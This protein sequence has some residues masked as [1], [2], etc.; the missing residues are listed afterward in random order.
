MDYLKKQENDF[1]LTFKNIKYEV[2][3]FNKDKKEYFNK[4]I[5]NNAVG[6]CKS[7]E[8]TAIMGPSGSGKTSLLNF[9]T[10]R[11]EFS[12]DST[13][14][15]KIYVNSQEISFEE[16]P[17]YSSYVMQ[18]DVL[19][20]VLT[21]YE[22]IKFGCQL[23]RLVEENTTEEC[24]NKFLSDLQLVACKDTLVG[25]PD[26]K[27]I[28][29]GERKRTSIGMELIS[30]PSILFL[31]EPTSG[32]D[33]Q[34]SL[35]VVSL[36]KRVA[37]EKNVAVICTIHQPS[38]NIFNIFDQLI[39]IERGNIIYNDSPV[40]ITSYFKS[41]GK[42]LNEHANPADAFMRT[43]EENVNRGEDPDFFINSYKDR[44]TNYDKEISKQ[45]E[46]SKVGNNL[47][48]KLNEAVNLWDATM[49]L[50]RRA[51]TNVLRNPNLLGA[52][53]GFTLLFGFMTAS[54]FWKLSGSNYDGIYGRIGFSFFV[55][56]N[57]FM[58]QVMGTILSFPIERAVFIREHS[59]KMYGVGEYYLAKNIVET[60]F[61]LFFTT[62][63]VI[64]VYFTAGLRNDGAEHFF[65]FL[66]G[67]LLHCLCAQSL[68]YAV[69]TLFSRVSE[70]MA[71]INILVMPFILFSG[72]LINDDSMPRWLHWIKYISPI[73][74]INEIVCLNE[75]ENN[76]DITYGGGG[77][78]VIDNLNLEIGKKNGF[79]VLGAM[80][81][82][83]RILG[84]VFLK[85]LI[86][87]TG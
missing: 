12:K 43:L 67:F 22:N 84:Y 7:G 30:N 2:K 20:D 31:D 71:T 26:M 87:K 65:I 42:P 58:S 50:S 35:K 54:V 72:T 86:R 1:T 75:F 85:L 57:I 49:I 27:G 78:E 61:I 79:I 76:P 10:N 13:H 83:Y 44:I 82:A 73:K 81:I 8:L 25:N 47:S 39:I 11:I 70:A 77:E 64:I 46:D 21:P 15:G 68:G 52:R 59:S 56:V 45:I 60:P 36:L 29:G 69:G 24:V 34:T 80:V 28:S 6:Q 14:E 32:L 33:S 51:F 74:Y 37:V 18:D 40:N 4:V 41:I 17:F 63:Y 16:I 9:I 5:I 48:S 53:I 3:V 55:A 62:V 38:S 19:F 23:K 66:A